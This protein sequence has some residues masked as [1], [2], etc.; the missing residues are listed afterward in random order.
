MARV[1]GGRHRAC[2][3]GLT[4]R[5]AASLQSARRLQAGARGQW[6]TPRK[7]TS[8]RAPAWRKTRAG[9]IRRAACNRGRRAQCAVWLITAVLQITVCRD[10]PHHALRAPAAIARCSSYCQLH[11]TGSA[12]SEGRACV[13]SCDWVQMP[14][15]RLYCG[16][17]PQSAPV[18]KAT[19]D[20]LIASLDDTF[21]DTGGIPAPVEG[22]LSRNPT[23]PHGCLQHYAG[24]RTLAGPGGICQGSQPG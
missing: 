13:N 21:I 9:T 7:G 16:V 14:W 2:H 15:M 17:L 20:A 6:T 18:P 24:T 10:Q 5:G 11:G 22:Q 12:R 1:G 19:Q 4:G 3:A 23:R 8:A